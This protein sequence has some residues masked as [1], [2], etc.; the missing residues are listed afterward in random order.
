MNSLIGIAGVLTILVIAGVLIGLLDRKNFAFEWLL[1]AALLVAIND[2]LLTRGYGVLP[3][4]IGGDWNWQGKLLALTV[5]L[6]VAASPVFGWARCG[7]VATQEPGSL[8]AALPIAAVYCAFFLV[9]ALAFPSDKASAEQVA[10]QLTMPGFEEELFYRGVLLF[11][12]DKAFMGR[13]RV[14]GVDWGWG[15]ILSCMLFGLAHAFGFSDGSFSFDAITMLLT[16][17][18]ALLAVWLRL[19]T[20]SLLLPVL[21]HNFG[22]SFSLLV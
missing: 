22:N 5:T 14:V 12:L 8:R 15:A 4:L 7:I 21:L 20:G 3:D 9:I 11:A 17:L 2:A 10:F 1:V 16:G 18:P 13:T 19:R 6:F